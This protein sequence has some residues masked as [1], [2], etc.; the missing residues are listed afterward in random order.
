M[1]FFT[2]LPNAAFL[3]Y[4]YKILSYF[5]R[6]RNPSTCKIVKLAFRSHFLLAHYAQLLTVFIFIRKELGTTKKAIVG[7]E[8]PT[9]AFN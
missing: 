7:N 5:F 4:L 3:R 6:K 9:M 1:L 2:R 8:L